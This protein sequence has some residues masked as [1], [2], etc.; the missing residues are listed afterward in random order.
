MTDNEDKEAILESTV[1][2]RL[3]EKQIAKC[4][5]DNNERYIT[6]RSIRVL[7]YSLIGSVLLIAGSVCVFVF[8]SGRW[9]SQIEGTAN[10]AKE[11]T[12]EIKNDQMREIN[13]ADQINQKLSA[14]SEMVSKIK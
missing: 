6:H 5:D 9:I 7:I 4:R 14:I 11:A 10:M 8:N 12:I 2:H 1:Y 3:C 13:R